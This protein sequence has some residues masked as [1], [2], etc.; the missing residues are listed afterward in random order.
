MSPH[1]R[2]RKHL[3]EVAQKD[4]LAYVGTLAGGLAHTVRTPLNSIQMNIQLAKEELA[5]LPEDKRAELD[6]YL[7]RVSRETANLQKIVNE[8]LSFARPPKLELI[9]TRLSEFIQNL[10]EFVEPEFDRNEI[11]I[12]CLFGNIEYPVHLDTYQFSHVIMNLLSN[13][14][15][16]VTERKK[17]KRIKGKITITTEELEREVLISI[18]DN[19]GG[20]DPKNKDKC[21]DGF[22][23]TKAQGAGLGLGIARRIVEEH[24]GRISFENNYPHGITFEVHLPKSI[25]LPFEDELKVIDEKE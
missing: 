15:D 8:F 7:A 25:Y 23:T 5:E 18:K 2:L 22:F 24:K 11:K 16:A 10:V 19:G 3:Q 4:R 9:P 1:E 20:I 6:K 14:R 17:T 21:F 13:S 12:D